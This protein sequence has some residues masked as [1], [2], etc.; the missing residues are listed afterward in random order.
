MKR[1]PS[2]LEFSLTVV[3]LLL[4]TCCVGL[5]V[6][7]WL[8]L[9]LEGP[10]K[11]TVL[12]GRMSITEGA[13]FSEELKNSSSLRF[14]SLAYDVQ[15]QVSKA[16]THSD[17][18]QVFK[19]CEVLYFSLGS[20]VVNFD[21]S[22]HQLIDVKDTEQQLWAGLLESG[23]GELV[24]DRNSIWITG[25]LQVTGKMWELCPPDHT[26]CA[27]QSMCVLINRLCDGV[28]DCPDA[29][30]EDATRCATVCDGQF[31]L[32]DLN[33]SFCSSNVSV[34]HNKSFCRWIV[35]LK[36][37]LS[38]E[39]K[40]HYFETEENVNVLKLYENIGVEKQLAAELSGSNPP[41]TVW[42][43]TDQSTV[44]FI[45]DDVNN[46]SGFKASYRAANLSNLSNQEKLTCTFER[47]MCFWRQQQEEDDGDWIRTSIPT[48]PPLS[49]PSV[50]HTLNNSSGFYMVT[51][52][53]PGQ[54]LK[55]FRMHSLR[56]SA[57]PQLMCLSF[58]YHMFGE[59]VHRLRV[60]LSG[61]PVIVVI[62]R[63]GNYGDNWNYGQVT[64][65]LTTETVVFEA[66]KKGGMRNDIAL[67]DITLT[68]DPCGPSPPEPT[69]VPPPTTA[70]P[71]PADCGG[72]FDLWEPN[73]TFSSP[74]Y[75]QSYGN[76]AHCV[77]TLHTREGRNIQLHFLD[78]DVEATYDIVEV[79]DGAG[80]NSYL[81]AVLTGGI[82]PSSDLFS[83]TNRMTV[84]FFTDV[85]GNG[86]G[87]R[88]NFTSG[89][90]LG[91]P[92]ACAV[93]QF[94]CRT[95]GCIHGNGECDGEVDC[96]DGSDELCGSTWD[97]GNSHLFYLLIP[98]VCS[99]GES[100]LLPARPEDSPFA[101]IRISSNGSLETSTSET[102]ISGEVISLTCDNQREVRVVGGVDAVKGAWPWIV[103]LQW[104]GRHVCGASVL[105][106]DWLLTA[107]H[108][109]YGKNLHLQS[110]SAVFGLHSQSDMNSLE[111]QTRR[112]DRIWIH[113][114][115]NRETKQADIAMMHLQQPISFSQFIQPLCLPAEG[116]EFTA[117]T[118]CLIAGWGQT[119]E[120]GDL[121]DVLQETNVALLVQDQCQ[122]QLPEYNITSSMLCAGHPEGGVDS[123]KGDSGGP[124]IYEDNGHWILI[125]V[126]SFGIGCGRP[127]RPGVYTR[128]S[129]F[130]S[131][132]AQTRR[133]SS[134]SS[135]SCC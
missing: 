58:W 38:V 20:V 70:P 37:G 1:A 47:G 116:Q 82:G 111:V 118:R 51:P 46:L 36:P 32:S 97:T 130:S 21:L 41:G 44:E 6:V 7:S 34:M 85:S 18:A 53:S 89:V 100:R 133:S 4:L 42:L 127:Q 27:N 31:I 13:V 123:C 40:F 10:A 87:F 134:S 124:L 30:D 121:P 132:I 81:L 98:T 9:K 104:R 122:H 88:A 96:P 135:S 63:D 83:T 103:S 5:I 33:G 12:T 66:L 131:W 16:F 129:A 115:Y 105:G 95:G 109:V 64:L 59:D 60:L 102:C 128:V 72:P 73:S 99:S 26:T 48:F 78:F 108:C 11:T 125:G 68:S 86:R 50:D 23:T 43:L 76:K 92:A 3:C 24:I 22:F 69:N 75:P 77:W 119:S 107:A 49:G 120:Q 17:L 35:R 71:I 94:Q 39:I 84:R 52:L 62:Q 25:Q 112:V 80:P 57:Q 8:S 15:Q 55:S 54:W 67:D 56:L 93:S 117:G 29:S 114:H 126:T 106:R 91:S 74:N 2:F 101:T 28:Q 110:W 79:R 61:P 45:S 113:R 14:K 90:N 65:N 19:S